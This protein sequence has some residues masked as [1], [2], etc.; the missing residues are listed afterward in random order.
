MFQVL[1][2]SCRLLIKYSST[3]ISKA[4]AK[5]LYSEKFHWLL[6]E[7]FAWHGRTQ[8]AEGSGK[9]D[10]GEMEEEEPPGQQI[11]ATDDED[12]LSIESFLGGM[13][14]Y[15]NTELTLAKRMSEAA[16]YTLFDVW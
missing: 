1:A 10:D 9:R 12:L 15:M 4:S 16:H 11:Q 14:L 13:N 8:T 5:M 7:D 6:I 2:S 3:I